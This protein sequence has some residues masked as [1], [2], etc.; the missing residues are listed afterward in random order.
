M[1]LANFTN[2]PGGLAHDMVVRASSLE[3]GR[4]TVICLLLCTLL[5][6]TR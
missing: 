6:M 3:C 5:H 4:T 1:C 2:H